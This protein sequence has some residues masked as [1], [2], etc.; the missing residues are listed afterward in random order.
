[1]KKVLKACAL[2]TTVVTGL[3]VFCGASANAEETPAQRRVP[4]F[5]CTVTW[6]SAGAMAKVTKTG[7][8]PADKTHDVIAVAD[9]QD[10][11]KSAGICGSSF[12]TDGSSSEVSLSVPTK[13]AGFNYTCTASQGTTTFACNPVR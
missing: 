8:N 6:G 10:G 13:K 3:A 11:K 5:S 2:V 4:T 12:Q 7:G 1:M 9:T